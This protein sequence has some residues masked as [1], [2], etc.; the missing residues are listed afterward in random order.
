M[1]FTNKISLGVDI[2]G[3]HISAA[4]VDLSTSS[5]L[6]G[7]C[8]QAYLDNKGEKDIILKTWA[9]TIAKTLGSCADISIEGIGVAVPGPFDYPHGRAMFTGN[10]KYEA[11]YDVDVRKELSQLLDFREENIHFFND[12]ASFALGAALQEKIAEKK[13]VGITLGTGFGASF[14]Q[15]GI[16][17]MKGQGIPE[18]G[19]LWDKPYKEG[20]ADDYFSTRWFLERNISLNGEA[21]TGVKELIEDKSSKSGEIFEEFTANLGEFLIPY[22]AAFGAEAILIGGNISRSHRYFL[23]P[24]RSAFLE[25]S[26]ILIQCVDNTEACNIIGASK[27]MSLGYW[28]R[29]QSP[30]SFF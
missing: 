17:V 18:N 7:T 24:L 26:N 6:Q 21:F 28:G 12:A 25:N 15:D 30:T 2:G 4:A 8:F 1:N 13:V 22:A 10:D 27:L 11:L 19:C 23:E 9:D 29:Q 20:I 16:P 3:S 5:I 14:L